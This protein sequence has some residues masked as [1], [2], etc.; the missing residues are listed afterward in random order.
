MAKIL[1]IDDDL[2][3]RDMLLQMM[4]MEGIDTISAENGKIALNILQNT[5]VDLII[6]DIVMPEKDGIETIVAIKKLMPQIPIIAMSGGGKIS[7]EV[8]LEMAQLLGARYS[9]T[10]PIDR[11]HLVI[12]VQNCLRKS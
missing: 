7:P 12:A 11:K 9:F 4:E 3:V 6:T 1:I 2:M 8:Y 10:K 5:S